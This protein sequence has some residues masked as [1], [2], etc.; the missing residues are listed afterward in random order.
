MIERMT[1]TFAVAIVPARQRR[2]RREEWSSDL[3][4]ARE[5]GM[6]RSSVL[7]GIVRVAMRAARLRPVIAIVSCAF[8]GVAVMLATVS[9]LLTLI[10]IVPI[11]ALTGLLV[12]PSTGP[13]DSFTVKSGIAAVVCVFVLT[14]FSR[15]PHLVDVSS[16]TTALV[17]GTTYAGLWLATWRV[18]L[19]IFESFL[20]LQRWHQMTGSGGSSLALLGLATVGLQRSTSPSDPATTMATLLGLAMLTLGILVAVAVTT[21]AVAR[22]LRLRARATH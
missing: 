11:I 10:E 20:G 6:R 7:W 5:L 21:P 1:L 16:P 19:S 17:L 8:V 3:T 22:R 18:A 4:F 2:D 13:W 9:G 15:A 14:T 12:V